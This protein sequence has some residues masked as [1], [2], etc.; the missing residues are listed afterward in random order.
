[1][2]RYI[3]CIA[4]LLVAL[5][6]LRAD[7]GV[8]LSVWPD[9]IIY[10]PGDTAQFAV[11]I[12]NTGKAP[13][14][15][16][17]TVRAIWEM[18][19][20]EQVGNQPVTLAA[21]ETKKLTFTWKAR[22]VLGGE[23]RADLVAAGQ[24]LA[25]AS[26]YFNVCP[27]KEV[28]RIALQTGAPTG[29]FSYNTPGYL[30][31]IPAAVLPVRQ[32]Y[33]NVME[34]FAWAPDNYADM[35]PKQEIWQDSYYESKTA[36]Q[37]MV[38]AGHAQGIKSTQYAT[39][40]TWSRPGYDL[41]RRHPEWTAYDLQGRP[42][43]AGVNV[44]WADVA[45]HPDPRAGY[46]ESGQCWSTY[47]DFD[48][49]APLDY[50]IKQLIDS[51]KMFGWDG[52]RFDGH[53]VVPTEYYSGCY[54]IDGKPLPAGEAA[55]KITA[56]ATLYTKQQVFQVFPDYLFMYN[57]ATYDPLHDRPLADGVSMASHG[58]L[59]T[60]ESYRTY[61]EVNS[62]FNAWSKFVGRMVKEADRC[63][64]LG[65]YA[66]AYMPPPWTVCPNVDRL[67][68]SLL[69]AAR[70][71]PFYACPTLDRPADDGGSHFP[72]QK[73]IFRFVTRFTA[74][75]WGRDEQRVVNPES[76]V[77]VDAAGPVWWKDY[78]YARQRADGK[79]FL[80]VQLINP[81]PTEFILGEKQPL[82]QPLT[83]VT[84]KFTQPVTKAWVGSWETPL[85]LYQAVDAPGGVV[86]VPRLGIWTMVVA[87][88]GGSK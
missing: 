18:D 71:H 40:Y 55:E 17:L 2:P 37:K 16:T 64:S 78:V 36:I 69:F 9:K 50:G 3:L 79:R 29:L 47:T 53:F 77:A 35:A 19:E 10:A 12:A 27:P 4:L 31:S 30:A 26:D 57:G 88:M 45:A 20:S 23:A 7:S 61:Y 13:L 65:G 43:A 58:G 8:T 52:V 87:E 54:T 1:M 39:G 42:R 80:I 68:Y 6:P 34:F 21:G 84:V 25:T 63:A 22:D 41:I 60:D 32:A 75:L 74:F 72:I 85:R 67:D 59:V 82:P 11:T 51:K 5:A 56:A 24:T 33:A 70:N 86:T 44:E 83:E 49:R 73:D 62:P 76:Q 14:A 81:P 15:A 66:G 46:T 28:M 48:Q 38:A